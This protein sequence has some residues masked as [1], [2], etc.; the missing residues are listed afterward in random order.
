[1]EFDEIIVGSGSSGAVL[2]ARLSEDRRRNVLLI[3]AGPDYPDIES[4][5]KSLLN[6]KMPASDHDW[7]FTAEMV[8]G[9]STQYPRGKVIGGTSSKNACLALRGTPADY[10]EWAA[11]GNPDW[12]WASVLPVLMRIEDD[13]EGAPDIHGRGGPVP[14]RRYSDGEH[15]PLQGAFVAACRALGFPA[16]LDHNHPEA[17]GVGNLPLNIDGTGV[18]ISTAIGYLLPARGLSNLAIQSDCLVNRVVFDGLRAIGVEVERDGV[19]ERILGR[20]VTLSGGAMGSPAILLRSGIGPADE[21]TALGIEPKSALGGVGRNLVDHAWI[22][23]AWNAAPDLVDEA[24][25]LVQV[26]LHHTAAGSGIDNDMQA[27]VCQ[28]PVQPMMCLAGMLVKPLS[29]GTLRLRSADARE[30]PDI[31]LGLTSHPE[32]ARRLRESV[33]LLSALVGTPQLAAVGSGNV[34]LGNGEAMSAARFADMAERDDWANAYVHQVVRHYVHPVGTARMG[35]AS[36]PAAVV[37]QHGRVHGLSGLRVADAS[38]MPTIPRA[39]THLTCVMIGERVAG[40]MRVQ[41]D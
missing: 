12:S 36:D 29:R 9:R 6:G 20:R 38:I 23:L 4:T 7:G 11:L 27:V 24:A 39:N 22:Q 28:E 10:D 30:Q 2:A 16:V 17:T 41:D 3:E 1:M 33:R 19:R 25:P 21:I 15:W 5:P 40:W 14:I 34:I 37:D 31:R 35:P 8:P 32:D 18:R 13:P 26:L